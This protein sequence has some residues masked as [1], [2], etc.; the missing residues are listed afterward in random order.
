M[1][2][3]QLSPVALFQI[4]KDIKMGP[5]RGYCT[6]TLFGVPCDPT[7]MDAAHPI[8]VT[9]AFPDFSSQGLQRSDCEKD[10]ADYERYCDDVHKNTLAHAE[11]LKKLNMDVV[12]VGTYTSRNSAS[13]LHFD[14]LKCLCD[15][16]RA[17]PYSFK[18]VVT[19]N[20]QSVS[21]KAFRISQATME[22]LEK[23]RYL[24]VDSVDK[25]DKRMLF[26]SMLVSVPVVFRHTAMDKLLLH[27]MLSSFSLISDVFRLR[28]MDTLKPE[29]DDL[30]DTMDE[31]TEDLGRPVGDKSKTKRFVYHSYEYHAKA[32]AV[33]TALNEE[34]LKMHALKA[35]GATNK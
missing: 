27:E 12:Q 31:L 22:Y 10:K 17:Y 33:K 9:N 25:V 32:K 23:S 2:P 8:E 13:I 15:E 4:I 16:Q 29:M 19:I 6:G 26:E 20:D 30:T 24:E 1:P 35:L 21:F 34:K 3:V 5:S 11:A 14:F 18:L 7:N 28:K